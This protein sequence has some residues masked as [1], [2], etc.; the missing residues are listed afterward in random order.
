MIQSRWDCGLAGC[1]WDGAWFVFL[2]FVEPSPNP[3]LQ[4][5]GISDSERFECF[6]AMKNIEMLRAL[7]R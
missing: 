3:S 5:R 7:G 1:G 4:R 2:W 6:L